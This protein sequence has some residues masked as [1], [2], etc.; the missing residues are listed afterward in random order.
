[1]ILAYAKHK[2]ADQLSSNCVADQ[3]ICFRYIVSTIPLHKS[4]ISSFY[5]SSVIIQPG[6]CPAWSKT[7]KRGFLMTQL[8]PRLWC[9]NVE[10][11]TIDGKGLIFRAGLSTAL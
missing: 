6:L 9:T 2:G 5:Q 1:M 8:I 3:H 10:Q 7:P 11:N 4:E